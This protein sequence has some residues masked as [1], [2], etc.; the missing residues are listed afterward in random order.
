MSCL[1]HIFLRDSVDSGWIS[2]IIG[3][4]G[5]GGIN[6]FRLAVSE[7]Y[8]HLMSSTMLLMMVICCGVA[9]LRDGTLVLIAL[10][11]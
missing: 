2:T 9:E 11:R 8:R 5:C 4:G 10:M 3:A 7:E 6:R 1:S